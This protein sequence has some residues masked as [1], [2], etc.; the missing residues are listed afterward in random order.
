MDTT[1]PATGHTTPPAIELKALSKRFGRVRAVDGLDLRI[2]PGEIV[3]FL[4][5]NGAGKTTALDMVLGLSEPTSG[6]ASV[7]GAAPHKAAASGRIAA[8][9]QTGGLLRDLSVKETVTAIASMFHARDRVPAVIERA[10]LTPI[11]GRR[12]GKCSGGEQQRLKFALALIPDPDVLVL[13]EPTAGMDVSARRHFW[14]VMRADAEAGRT[15]VFAT[16]YL[17]EAEEFAARTVVI[18]RGRLVADAPTRDLRASLGGRSVSA[19]VPR[20]ALE[21][22]GALPGISHV[23]VEQASSPAGAEGLATHLAGAPHRDEAAGPDEV[24]VR[25]RAEDSDAVARVLLNDLGGHRLRVTEPSLETA[26]TELTSAASDSIEPEPTEPDSTEP[27][28]TEPTS[29]GSAS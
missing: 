7:L 14:D 8:V 9:L 15:V 24:R 3:A 4:G 10:G 13:D 11:L 17:Q 21:R 23:E 16:H 25:L 6:T 2:D 18:S 28:P 1:T 19:L 29:T 22:L 12:V 20:G 5:P 27:E 26:F